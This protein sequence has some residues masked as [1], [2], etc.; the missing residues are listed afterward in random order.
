MVNYQF[1]VEDA[2][3]A[4]PTLYFVETVDDARATELAF[5]KLGE[6]SF[7]LGVE[8]RKGDIRVVGL[9]SLRVERGPGALYGRA[10]S[11]L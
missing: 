5:R 3:Y 6:N 7:H 10:A 4:V 1:Y 8:V 11:H 2:R 9:G